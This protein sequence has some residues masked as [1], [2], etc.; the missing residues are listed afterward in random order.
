MKKKTNAEPTL[1]QKIDSEGLTECRWFNEK[2]F[3]L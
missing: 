3:R 1:V 2:E